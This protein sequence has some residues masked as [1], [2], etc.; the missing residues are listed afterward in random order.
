MSPDIYT[1]PLYMHVSETY[2]QYTVI[3]ILYS[4]K[5]SYRGYLENQWWE[6]ME[7]SHMAPDI[8]TPVLY[9]HT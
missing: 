7:K 8:Y 1:P 3:C 2:L 9:I 4:N 6:H 5:K